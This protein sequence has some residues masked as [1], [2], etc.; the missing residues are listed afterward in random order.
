M[1]QS[2]AE[3]C[4]KI[5]LC[6]TV[7]CT[8]RYSDRLFSSG[9]LV[10]RESGSSRF[11]Q[12]F[13]SRDV[14][15][16]MSYVCRVP[17]PCPETSFATTSSGKRLALKQTKNGCMACLDSWVFVCERMGENWRAVPRAV[18]VYAMPCALRALTTRTS[19]GS[20]STSPI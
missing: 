10:V 16:H 4:R 13:L 17:H 2:W 18:L 6:N 7:S 11:R 9:S 1:Q 19:A 20:Q 12:G 3:I 15:S 8:S 5:D 14:T